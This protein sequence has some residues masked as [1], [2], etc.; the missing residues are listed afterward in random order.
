M[1]RS[2]DIKPDTTQRPDRAAHP[3]HPPMSM[4][5]R[6]KQFMPF[7]AVRGY[8]QALR[9][10]EEEWAENAEALLGNP[11]GVKE[12]ADP[13]TVP[14]AGSQTGMESEPQTESQAGPQAGPGRR[15]R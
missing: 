9:R 2:A 5:E 14:E 8:D 10:K 1:S 6:A 4:E 11:L 12:E 3:H 13:E 15:D 7:A